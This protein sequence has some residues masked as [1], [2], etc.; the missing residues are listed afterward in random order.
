MTPLTVLPLAFVLAGLSPDRAD[1][2]PPNS[3]S[4]TPVQDA[5]EKADGRS[6]SAMPPLISRVLSG[7]D[8]A[9]VAKLKAMS[10]DEIQ[11]LLDRANRGEE[12]SEEESEL[13]KAAE[14]ALRRDF[15]RNLKFMDGTVGLP[16]IATLELPDELR[17]LGPEDSKRV[18]QQL[19]GNAPREGLLGM[20]V[21]SEVSLVNPRNGWAIVITHESKGYV[22]DSDA[23]ALA[24]DELLA[25]LQ[26]A[27]RAAQ[28]A[29]ERRGHPGLELAGWH[30]PPRYDAE[31]HT[32]RWSEEV[33]SGATEQTLLNDR[34]FV[35]VRDGALAFEAVAPLGM[36]EHVTATMDALREYVVIDEGMRYDDFDPNEDPPARLDL[37]GVVLGKSQRHGGKPPWGLA[38]VAG[39]CAIAFGAGLGLFGR[40]RRPIGPSKAPA[41]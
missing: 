20:L 25:G 22:D 35:L 24:P 32:L 6:L 28:R 8:P 30:D 36:G 1:A 5:G 21:H 31:A 37:A 26:R 2:P 13:A 3:A 4:R 23:D 17:Y 29:A 41:T 12:L 14:T 11:A 38:L 19:W 18:F 39:V 10:D 34:M 16:G 27:A 7:L 33:V 40:R 9:T 15:L